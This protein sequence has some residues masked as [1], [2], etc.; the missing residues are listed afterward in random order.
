MSRTVIGFT[1]H[2]FCFTKA[3]IE[4]S[5]LRLS[6][7][8]SLNNSIW[9]V[10]KKYFGCTS[11]WFRAILLR[12][13]SLAFSETH[14]FFIQ[15]SYIVFLTFYLGLSLYGCLQIALQWASSSFTSICNRNFWCLWKVFREVPN[16]HAIDFTK[17]FSLILDETTAICIALHATETF[18]RL[19]L[20]IEFIALF[21]FCITFSSIFFIFGW[22]LNIQ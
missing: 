6:Y 19:D 16:A 4:T 11:Y 1:Y 8:N 10:S 12:I 15:Y 2:G 7:L 22:F 21:I 9:L 5:I 20:L 17:R 14:E 13:T 3:L 18:F